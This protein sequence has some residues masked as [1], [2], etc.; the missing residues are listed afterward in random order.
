M[1]GF[2]PGG[3][4]NQQV[5]S[6]QGVRGRG[7]GQMRG[8]NRGNRTAGVPRV[9]M[10]QDGQ[11]HV[12]VKG[13][14]TL[15]H[16]RTQAI[17]S[18]IKAKQTLAQL[19]AKQRQ[20]QNR[21]QLVNQ[22]RGLQATVPSR[23]RGRG[24]SSYSSTLSINSSVSTARGRGRIQQYGSTISLNSVA[25]QRS[26]GRARG[27]QRLGST[28]SINSV[29]S[30]RGRGRGRGIQRL[31]STMSI[32][33]VGS[34]ASQRRRWRQPKVPVDD[35]LLTIS[36]QNSPPKPRKNK[37]PRYNLQDTDPTLQ[38][39]IASLKPAVPMKYQFKKNMFCQATTSTSLNDRFSAQPNATAVP[40]D[41]QL[42]RKVFF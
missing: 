40:A 32:N 28:M 37:I 21:T 25:S 31:G 4:Q 7:R 11:Q 9:L 26:R 29:G 22:K 19:N 27:L 10:T 16:Q 34:Q 3:R 33:S 36:V 15:T 30:Q 42:G 23:G 24:M 18:L 41:N 35:S 39:Q 12:G 5:T 2:S 38:A 20:R 1:T 6:P 17:N 8:R 13:L 14:T